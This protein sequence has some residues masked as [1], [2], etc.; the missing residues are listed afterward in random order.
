MVVRAFHLTRTTAGGNGQNPAKLVQSVGAFGE[1]MKTKRDSRRIPSSWESLLDQVTIEFGSAVD[2]RCEPE[3]QSR[4][5]IMP[6]EQMHLIHGGE[7]EYGFGGTLH[8]AGAGCIAFCPP[9]VE[10]WARRVSR[11]LV[12]LTVIHF[13]SRFPG[14]KRYLDAFN[15]AS[16]IRLKPPLWRRLDGTARELCALHAVRPPGHALRELALI[17]DFFYDLFGLRGDSTPV[18]RDGERVL[19]LIRHMKR[20]YREKITLESLSRLVFVSPNHLSTI[21][22]QYTGRSPIDFL[23]QVRLD[24]ARRLLHSCEF[25]VG[26]ICNMV[27]CEDPAYFS[28]MF[29]R[30]AGMSPSAYRRERWDLL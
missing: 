24:E 23:I 7:L 22:R 27:G 10:W 11:T 26:E 30:H 13:Q 29:H 1:I 5:R 17:H 21:F 9:G 14:G 16:V 25:R 12:R 4:P 19:K 15:F 8:R 6:D 2:Y 18:D 28:R 3:W 20:D